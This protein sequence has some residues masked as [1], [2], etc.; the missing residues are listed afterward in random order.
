M[1]TKPVAVQLVCALLFAL[2]V[3]AVGAVRGPA[4]PVGAQGTP[5]PVA[6][7][8]PACAITPRLNEGFES[9]TL[10]A[11]TSVVS[12]CTPGGCGWSS[13]T[14]ASHTGTYSAF[15]PD[16]NNVAD[17]QLTLAGAIPL[18]GT[19]LITATLTFWHRFRFEGS[20]GN[21]YDGGVLETSID[22]GTTWQGAQAYFTSGGYNG[23]IST[24]FG[25]PLAGRSAWSQTS[26]AYPTFNQVRVNLM[27]FAGKNLLFRF[28][29]GDDSS[30]SSDG[31]WVDDIL[32]TL[33]TFKCS[34]YMPLIERSSASASEQTAAGFADNDANVVNHDTTTSAKYDLLGALLRGIASWLGR[35]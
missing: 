24:G 21:F 31:W 15:S 16:L 30:I 14:S 29:Q 1:K 2:V 35:E 20:G 18:P 6:I 32:V 25:N 8:T 26:P 27:S 7:P 17:Q 3:L 13:T 9:G 23:F 22:S 12:T 10:G 11:F 28:R 34:G 19:G 4:M 5:T 33:A